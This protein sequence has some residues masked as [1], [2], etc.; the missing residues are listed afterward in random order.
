LQPQ[1]DM[2]VNTECNIKNQMGNNG[3]DINVNRVQSP[4]RID[5]KFNF[6]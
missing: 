4:N 5:P 2:N 6:A 1:N 3:H